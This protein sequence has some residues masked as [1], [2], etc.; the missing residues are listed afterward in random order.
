MALQISNL[1][2][3]VN[4]YTSFL[5]QLGADYVP[6]AAAQLDYYS[7]LNNAYLYTGNKAALFSADIGLHEHLF[8]YAPCVKNSSPNT[9]P[10]TNVFF[11]INGMT[12]EKNPETQSTK[13]RTGYISSPI[14]PAAMYNSEGNSLPA[15][16]EITS[17]NVRFKESTEG[18]Y[19][20]FE[21][22]PNAHLKLNTDNM[23]FINDSDTF[24][25]S[26]IFFISP[27]TAEDF[28][29]KMDSIDTYKNE[30]F[31]AMS[32]MAAVAAVIPDPSTLAEPNRIFGD[33]YKEAADMLMEAARTFKKYA[34]KD[35]ALGASLRSA[36][37]YTNV[38][39]A[40]DKTT[41]DLLNVLIDSREKAES[42]VEILEKNG[43]GNFN[44]WPSSK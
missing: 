5:S 17:Y 27:D 38:I 28:R 11:E 14:S 42:V 37:L 22:G 9:G 12:E 26:A 44:V 6:M 15:I 25:E 8:A 30:L 36:Y 2:T 39:N 21:I 41:R 13:I 18:V 16:G 1:Q 40:R 34:W 3:M 7:S 32:I 20:G 10:L 29:L 19:N 4:Q 24:L 31:R 23:T 33:N 35:H 43:M